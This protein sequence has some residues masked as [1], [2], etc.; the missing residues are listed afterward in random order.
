MCIYELRIYEL[1]FMN[2]EFTSCE[3]PRP[4]PPPRKRGGGVRLRPQCVLFVYSL[5]APWRPHLLEMHGFSG[6]SLGAAWRLHLLEMHG[7]SVLFFECGL[8]TAPLAFVCVL[9]G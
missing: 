4:L 8:E 6:Y 1:G 5:G 9:G 3:L 2:Y 7:V